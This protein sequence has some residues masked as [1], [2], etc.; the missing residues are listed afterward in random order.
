MSVTWFQTVNSYS[1]CRFK[2]G[3]EL[4]SLTWS[5]LEAHGLAPH[6]TAVVCKEQV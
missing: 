3:E 2:F 6:F 1:N 4:T 5:S